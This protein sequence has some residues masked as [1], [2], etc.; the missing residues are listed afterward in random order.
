[1]F[2]TSSAKVLWTGLGARLLSRGGS[3]LSTLEV[4]TVQLASGH[5]M[6]LFG[7]GTYALPPEHTAAAVKSALESGYRV[8]AHEF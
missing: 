1:M 8:G 6:P 7:L 2:V 4:P 3:T 5:Q